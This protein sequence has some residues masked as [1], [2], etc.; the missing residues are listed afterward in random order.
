MK[1]KLNA[2]ERDKDELEK[3]V[4][5]L[6]AEMKEHKSAQMRTESDSAKTAG[7]MDEVA[8]LKTAAR[9]HLVIIMVDDVGYNDVGWRN[10]AVSTPFLD[11]LL[12]NHS[13]PTT[14]LTRHYTYHNLSAAAQVHGRLPT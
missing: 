13:E 12:A 2:S 10:P 6:Q 4:A 8:A 1:K 5:E 14:V 7:L 11:G 3:Q 9:P